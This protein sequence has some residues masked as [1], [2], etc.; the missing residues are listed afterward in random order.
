MEPLVPH[1]G[2]RYPVHQKPMRGKQDSS[3]IRVVAGQGSH[4]MHLSSSR[5]LSSLLSR[6]VSPSPVRLLWSTSSRSMGFQSPLV[7]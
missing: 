4:A 1:W 6:R 5:Q 3:L 7:P 2:G